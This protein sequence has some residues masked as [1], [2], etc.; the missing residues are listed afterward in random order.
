MGREGVVAVSHKSS[1]ELVM[2]II[3]RAAAGESALEAIEVA[4]PQILEEI[5]ERQR[6]LRMLESLKDWEVRA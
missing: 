3:R 5:T 2:N 4:V 1:K 6:M